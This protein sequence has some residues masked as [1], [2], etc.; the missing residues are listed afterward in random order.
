MV[1]GQAVYTG[2]TPAARVYEVQ[3]PVADA[4]NDGVVNVYDIDPFVLGVTYEAEYRR[5]YCGL[6][7]SWLYH[8]DADCSGAVNAFDI[9]AFVLK[10][11]NP[12]AW[13][14]KYPDCEN[15]DCEPL[16]DRMEGESGDD[17]AAEPGPAEV[18][19]LMTEHLDPAN[20]PALIAAA[21][22]LA[23]GLDDPDRAEL[24]AGIAAALSGE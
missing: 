17:P 14:L 20:L 11:T 3:C 10:L 21:E 19:A 13:H 1:V 24:W 5:T 8:M 22:T 6:A 7:G 18:A 23:A 2:N 4:N 15:P 9:D 12:T 16:L